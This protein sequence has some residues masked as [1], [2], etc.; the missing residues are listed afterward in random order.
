MLTERKISSKARYA[1]WLVIPVFLILNCFISIPVQMPSALQYTNT[2]NSSG[3][4]QITNSNTSSVV[5]VQS[6]TTQSHLSVET[7]FLIIGL[8]LFVILLLY[9]LVFYLRIR[10]NR[11]FMEKDDETGLN[12]Y[13]L[14]FRGSP[15]LFGR[16]VYVEEDLYE[17]K[18]M[19]HHIL[20]HEAGHAS[21]GDSFWIFVRYLILCLFWYDPLTWIAFHLSHEDSEFAADERVMAK[22]GKDNRKA[23]GE[24]L[25][26]LAADPRYSTRFSM[27]PL[28][29]SEKGGTMKKRIQHIA[30]GLTKTN[31]GILILVSIL[32]FA[33]V[34]CS[35]TEPTSTVSASSISTDGV[36]NAAAP[37]I[38]INGRHYHGTGLT[39]ENRQY[40]ADGLITSTVDGTMIPEEN[41]QS[42]FGTGYE[43][44]IISDDVIYVHIEGKWIRYEYYEYE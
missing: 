5:T 10:K 40:Q 32:I 6:V 26:E 24:T 3:T 2:D 39:N 17:R 41:D 12:V 15:F 34:G 33:L 19:L 16:N 30:A 38:M 18:D 7:V 25:I 14:S 29:M 4:L 23:Y 9:N 1:L 44:D 27:Q 42:N 13:V 36:S 20:L 37:N 43:Y 22:I 28:N 8:S 11:K 35:L 21:Q 31:K